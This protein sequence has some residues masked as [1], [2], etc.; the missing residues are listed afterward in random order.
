MMQNSTTNSKFLYTTQSEVPS[1]YA[2]APDLL[3]EM[4][5]DTQKA[6]PSSFY[7]TPTYQY[8][9]LNYPQNHLFSFSP[10]AQ[11]EIKL[12]EKKVEINSPSGKNTYSTQQ[13]LAVGIEQ[14]VLLLPLLLGAILL[15]LVVVSMYRQALSRHWAMLLLLS[16]FILLYWGGK[17]SRQLFVR[18]S[19][20]N[21]FFLLGF[22][23]THAQQFVS[24]LL[25][26]KR[27]QK[28]IK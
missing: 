27:K 15:A 8:Q 10:Q 24:S 16:S 12:F 26:L 18:T 5:K 2:S 22:D 7:S 19:L 11:T 28:T 9:W 1:F 21:H 6:S 3:Q 20:Q 14:K 17:G 13:V 25:A 23:Q 4:H